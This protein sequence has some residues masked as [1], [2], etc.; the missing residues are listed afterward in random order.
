M[1]RYITYSGGEYL[2]IRTAVVTDYPELRNIYLESRRAR[3]HWTNPEHMSLQDFDADTVDEHIIV[4]EQE[5]GQILGFAS[6][7]LP[8]HFIH[9]LFIHPGF[10]GGGTGSRLLD[11]S[12]SLMQQPVRLKCVSDNHKAIGFY[13]RQGWKKVIEEGKP[14]EKYWVME[15]DTRA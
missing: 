9:L 12:I 4:A 3:F 6:L 13:E 11:A 7:Y 10:M 14:G 15:Y 8:D 1:V 2:N 5:D